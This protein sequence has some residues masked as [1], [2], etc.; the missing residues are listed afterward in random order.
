MYISESAP[1]QIRGSLAV[2]FNLVILTSLTIAFWINYGVSEWQTLEDAQWRIPMGIQMV[3]GALLFAGMI[4]QK[5]SPRYLITKDR[6]E[7]AAKTLETLRQ[8]K[9][10]HPFIRTEMQEITESVMAG[11]ASN[12]PESR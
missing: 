12:C 11:K 10:D 9:A 4:F 2:C 3:P 1:K 7:E 6:Y 8:L 5:E